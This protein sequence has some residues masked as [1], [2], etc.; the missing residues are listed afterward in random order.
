M[1]ASQIICQLKNCLKYFQAEAVPVSQN[2][3][4]VEVE[5]C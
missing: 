2:I 4:Q 3:F 1:L 5:M